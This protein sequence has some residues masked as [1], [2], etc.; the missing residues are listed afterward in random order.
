MDKELV[1]EALKVEACLQLICYIRDYSEEND[2][3]LVV[4]GIEDNLMFEKMLAI[5]IPFMQGYYL[6]HPQLPEYWID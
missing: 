4:E 2:I 5:N 1:Y 3:S 6:Y